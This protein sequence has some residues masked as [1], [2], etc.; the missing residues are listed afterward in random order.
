MNI[1]KA[2]ALV[3]GASTGIGAVY[4]DR[5]AKRGYNLILIARDKSKLDE[6]ASRIRNATGV[7]V[8]TESADLAA[9][10]GVA[11]LERCLAQNP[12]ISL[13]INNAGMGVKGTLLDV[14]VND[15]E[16]MLNLNVIGFT[17]LALAAANAFSS[18]G[19]GAIVNV[20][21]IVPFLPEKFGGVYAATKAYVLSLTQSLQTKFDKTGI[22]VQ[23]V[24]PGA[25]RTAIWEKSGK[26]VNAFPPQMVMEADAMV[27]AALAGFDQRELV[28]IPSLPDVAA[29]EAFEKARLTLAPGLSRQHPAERY[30]LAR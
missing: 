30:R 9:P 24:L 20:G 26:D 16:R 15:V 5:L 18:R 3:T 11:K 4:A 2:V 19:E 23:A 22:Y 13:F 27:D 8:E 14:D 1:K 21:S 7:T 12:S 25:T 28:T 17:R 29:W 6:V 10:E